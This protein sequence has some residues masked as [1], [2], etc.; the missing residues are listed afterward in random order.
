MPDARQLER[1]LQELNREGINDPRV[2]GAL[3]RVPR[4]LFVPSE[5]RSQA[6][7][8]I[9]LPIGHGQTIS[10][11]YVVAVMTQALSLTG[12]ES[13]LEVGTG[14]GYQCAVLA[15]LCRN[16]TSIERIDSLATSARALLARLG[17][18]NVDI[19]VGDGSQGC[20][21]R[22]P[23]DAIMVTAASPSVPQALVD[24]LAD[25]GRLILPVGPHHT[26]EL[27]LHI[28]RAEGLVSHQ[29]G[30]VRFVPLIGTAGWKEQDAESFRQEGW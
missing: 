7:L 14:S 23:F 20:P 12:S 8:N 6:L 17:Y 24:Q 29:L 9:P 26:Q 16:V 1:L 27:A 18:P 19:R 4:E 13:V 3:E 11:P 25:G 15:E 5:Y 28:K 22:A 30:G 21:D 2:L 10:Q